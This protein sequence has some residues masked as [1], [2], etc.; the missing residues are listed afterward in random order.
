[1][2]DGEEGDTEE[3]KRT[4]NRM[5]DPVGEV[6]TASEAFGI[7]RRQVGTDS[8]PFGI[9][10]PGLG[11]STLETRRQAALEA[12]LQTQTDPIPVNTS[13]SRFPPHAES[14]MAGGDDEVHSFDT[15][16][17]YDFILMRKGHEDDTGVVAQ[18]EIP[19]P[20]Q[21]QTQMSDGGVQ[22][23]NIP[24]IRLESEESVTLEDRVIVEVAPR[25]LSTPGFIRLFTNNDPQ[26]AGHT[27]AGILASVQGPAGQVGMYTIATSN[28][29]GTSVGHLHALTINPFLHTVDL[30]GDG[31]ATQGMRLQNVKDPLFGK[32]AANKDY[33]DGLTAVVAAEGDIIIGDA[34]PAWIVLSVGTARQLLQVNAG[35]TRPEWAS[36]I[37]IPGTLD[38]TGAVVLDSTLSINDANF[39]LAIVGLDP[40]ITFDSTDYME[41]V[42]ASNRWFWVVGGAEQARLGTSSFDMTDSGDFDIYAS[43][44]DIQPR[45]RFS[46]NSI[47]WG[48]GGGSTQDVVLSRQAANELLLAAGDTLFIGDGGGMVIGHTAQVAINNTPELQ[49]LGN[50][51]PD[52]SILIGRWVSNPNSPLLNFVKSRNATIGSHTIVAD[53]DKI[54]ELRFFPDDGV[55]FATQAARFRAEVDDATPAAGDVGMAFVWEQMPGGGGALRETM[56]ITAAGNLELIGTVD[57][58]DIAARDHAQAHAAAEHNAATLPGSA[59]ENL[60]AFYL[61]IDD[62]TVP[63]N[64]ASTVRRLFVDT[65]TGALSVR[66]SAGATINLEA[67]GGYTDAQAIAAV[68]GEATLEL[69]GVVGLAS[70][71]EMDEI[72]DPGAGA[73]NT[74]RV[75]AIDVAGTTGLQITDSA[76]VDTTIVAR[77]RKL[78]M[79]MMV[80]PSGNIAGQAGYL[81]AVTRD[82]HA[83][84][85]VPSDWVA[86]TDIM[87]SMQL[88][89]LGAVVETAVMNNWIA[90]HSDGETW[91]WN[92]ESNVNANVNIP[93]SSGIVIYT[94][95]ISGAS[96]SAG[97]HL[98]WFLR[99]TGGSA[100]D[101]LNETLFIRGPFMEYTAFF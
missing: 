35:G 100:S 8:T 19:A 20:A 26:D 11:S 63:A 9:L 7:D 3:A 55:D 25:N 17:V 21:A 15:I 86:G 95:T 58:V 65:A 70:Y 33:V 32:D 44:A 2:P 31:E 23:Y 43:F 92:I 97:D 4:P 66:T 51:G 68:E 84:A 61:D 53:N 56:R 12:V 88:Y 18:E 77:T 101:T 16:S 73:A 39:A 74:L 90:A 69:S 79:T 34:T 22:Q 48:P 40:R 41:Y 98:E 5:P 45:G 46:A 36:N 83:A 49:V 59:N 47:R 52:S 76:G 78:P 72:A 37:D 81:D 67:G 80:E 89:K 82:M 99:R 71:L 10:S 27:E 62:I 54:G 6:V 75:Y 64:P 60:G 94:R 24:V 96:L 1:M 85:P 57:G 91:S 29:H 42:R 87:L 50:T 13:P 38:V 14:H 28:T 93:A 30:P